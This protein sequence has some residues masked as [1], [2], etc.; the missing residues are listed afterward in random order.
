M[1]GVQGLTETSVRQAKV[2]VRLIERQL[3]AQPLLAL[4]QRADPS[5]DR[6]DMLAHRQVDTLD[7]RGIDMQAAKKLF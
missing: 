1:A 3:L 5:S 4:A 6:R 7:E 2:V